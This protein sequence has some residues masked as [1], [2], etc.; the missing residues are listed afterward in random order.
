VRKF[1]IG[2]IGAGRSA[3]IM[4][5]ENAR[6]MGLLAAK[7]GWVVASGGRNAGIMQAVNAGAKQIE[8][9]C[10]V[11]ILPSSSARP[12]PD[13]DV[14]IQTEMHNARNNILVLTSDILV[15]CGD[16]G[17]GT[18]SEIALA[19]KAGKTVI[20]LGTSA[21]S[22]QFFRKMGG[23]LIQAAETP[24]HAMYLIKKYKRRLKILF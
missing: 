23:E 16:G 24:V 19:T 21:E 18:V 4:D 10:T 9:S 2:V 14:V 11:G 7:Q 13:V 20:L 8:G 6:T 22:E 5:M 1:I 17:P 3:R 15:A 12:C